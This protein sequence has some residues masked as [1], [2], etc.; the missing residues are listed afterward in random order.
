MRTASATLGVV[1]FAAGLAG[2]WL[3][4]SA[5]ALDA[6]VLLGP[7]GAGHGATPT[8]SWETVTGADS[9]QLYVNYVGTTF[10]SATYGASDLTVCDATTCSVTPSET[11]YVGLYSWSVI[12]IESGMQGPP[13]AT[14]EFNVGT[15]PT[16]TPVLVAPSQ[17]E[18][19]VP[20]QPTLTW[21]PSTGA[22]AYALRVQ[23]SATGTLVVDEIHLPTVCDPTECS[24]TLSIQLA[25]GDHVWAVEPRNPAG[26]GPPSIVGVFTV[27]TP[28]TAPVQLGPTG[29]ITT[30]YPTLHWSPVAGASS[31]QIGVYV[32]PPPPGATPV[33][34]D[35]GYPLTHCDETDC[36]LTVDVSPP[37]GDYIWYVRADND[38]GQG[39]TWSVGQSFSLDAPT[40]STLVGAGPRFSSVTWT[41]DGSPYI[42]TG[43]VDIYATLTI[44]PGVQV[45]FDDGMLL[46]IFGELNAVGTEVEPIVFTSNSGSP[47]PGSWKAIAFQNYSSP[48]SRIENAVVEYAGGDVTTQKSI[49]IAE[50]SPLLKNVWIRSGAGDGVYITG[51]G[52]NPRLERLVVWIPGEH[53]VY[54]NGGGFHVEDLVIAGT[55]GEYSLSFPVSTVWTG[56]TARYVDKRI[57]IR[58]GEINGSDEEEAVTLF[59]LGVPYHSPG[60]IT[61]RNDLAEPASLTIA[62]G[63]EIQFGAASLLTVGDSAGLLGRLIARGTPTSFITFTSAQQSKSAG[64]WDRI[65]FQRGATP[66]SVLEYASVEYAGKSSTAGAIRVLNS[67]PT[68]SRSGIANSGSYGIFVSGTAM[69]KLTANVFVSTSSE[70]VFNNTSVPIDARAGW[71]GDASGP[72]VEGPG[73]GLSV[74]QNVLF[75]PWATTIINPLS[76]AVD[77]NISKTT[78]DKDLDQT[79]LTATLSAPTAWVLHVRDAVTS[80]EVRRYFGYGETAS[81][82]WDGK[83]ANGTSVPNGDYDVRLLANDVL[84]EELMA[85]ILS[86]VTVTGGTTNLPIA[87]VSSPAPGAVL[88]KGSLAIQGF[89]YDTNDF[90]SYTLDY[91]LGTAPTSWTEIGTFMTAVQGADLTPTPWDTSSLNGTTYTLRL[92][93]RDGTSTNPDAVEQLAV[94]FFEIVDVNVVNPSFSGLP[95]SATPTSTVS[96]S[97]SLSADWAVDIRNDASLIVRTF[98]GSSS[99]VSAIWDGKDDGGLDLVDGVYSYTLSATHA[100]SGVQATPVGGNIVLDSGDPTVAIVSPT[101]LSPVSNIVD[102]VGTATDDADFASYR[103]DYALD[104]SPDWRLIYDSASEETNPGPV[105]NGTLGQWITNDFTERRPLFIGPGVGGYKLRLQARDVA[106]NIAEHVVNVTLS[107]VFITDISSSS[108]EIQPDPSGSVTVNFNLSEPADVI[109]RIVPETED[110]KV[111]PDM[112]AESNAVYSV[113]LPGLGAG[114]RSFDWDGR[115]NNGDLVGDEAYIYVIEATSTS[116]GARDKFNQF[117]YNKYTNPT[118]KFF[119]IADTEYSPQKNDFIVDNVFVDGGPGRGSFWIEYDTSGSTTQSFF[120]ER[121]RL[122]S[123]GSNDIVWDGRG[124]SGGILKDIT[125]IR[126][127][128]TGF[129]TACAPCTSPDD[130]RLL[131]GVKNNYI[132]VQGTVPGIVAG[133]VKADPFV[134]VLSYGQVSTLKFELTRDANVTV[135]VEDHNGSFVTNL[136]NDE[137][138]GPGPHEVLWD[139]TVPTGGPPNAI[140]GQ[141]ADFTFIIRA[142]NPNNSALFVERKAN[143][144]VE[145]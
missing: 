48:F 134:V 125:D 67:S 112:T 11:H 119:N 82:A 126:Y 124:T 19:G 95:G 16:G 110:F 143:V 90:V 114:A 136:L 47:A 31:Y 51:P 32:D 116:S 59:N 132:E 58:G 25:N 28:T 71:W 23:E 30:A 96:G 144:I 15:P 39:A 70:A 98:S 66:D 101:E 50:S 140:V 97:L 80:Q 88:A 12:A 13:S 52:S 34:S 120:A 102:I 89:A 55:P 36:Y 49:S 43:N 85:P 40:T 14:W 127:M 29:T 45:R 1:A 131:Y 130:V 113:S 35:V 111:A 27:G 86:T 139:G 7:T 18:T 142:S 46:R 92:T 22:T 133:S 123:N 81:Q 137:L 94:N 87:V 121:G 93:T 91:G 122:F 69:P 20:P 129:D 5:H 128:V 109:A 54:L 100:G 57:E 145:R 77:A 37:N 78:F 21:T 74:G 3:P 83:D 65:E 118:P 44:E 61:V 141:P 106:G 103:L 41:R 76:L 105:V 42:V 64:D 4:A 75:E 107:N 73:T 6:P 115:D 60:N 26:A 84:Q 72:S 24:V 17:N 79:T 2:L 62:P 8:Y 56:G 63:V 9:Y 135:H 99:A 68:I 10:L 108:S 33:Y 53:G 104:G 138:L 38:A 117:H